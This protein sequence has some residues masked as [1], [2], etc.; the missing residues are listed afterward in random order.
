MTSDNIIP[1][2]LFTESRTIAVVGLS[3]K[4]DRPSFGVARVMQQHGYRIVP[5][6]LNSAGTSILGEY[7][8]ADLIQ[9]HEALKMQGASI[10][11]VDCFRKSADI[12]P[13]VDKAIQIGARIIWMQSGISHAGAAAKA[14]AAG[15]TV[16][17]DRCLKIE[18]MQWRVCQPG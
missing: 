11:I 12:P 3:A 1:D 2:K 16:I 4:S 18:Y 10:D 7:C 5:V 14:R 6:N 13:V 8:Y 15:M 9:A 17:M